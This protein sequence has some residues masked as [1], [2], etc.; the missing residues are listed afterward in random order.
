MP[1]PC[2]TRDPVVQII[3]IMIQTITPPCSPKLLATGVALGLGLLG[4]NLQAGDPVPAARQYLIAKGVHYIQT[5]PGTPVLVTNAPYQAMANV[6]PISSA[7]IF[8]VTLMIPGGD[9]LTLNT[10]DFDSQ[11]EIKDSFS[12]RAAMDAAVPNGTYTFTI[13]GADGTH[14][15]SLSLS[16]DKYPNAPHISNWAAL[17]NADGSGDILITWNAFAGGTT[18]DFVQVFVEDDMGNRFSSG[19]GPGSPDALN[20]TNTSF[21]IPAN[22][23]AGGGHFTG[24]ILFGRGS[25][26]T[27][28]YSGVQGIA[29]YFK[30]TRFSLSTTS[31]PPEAGR[32]RFA[33]S[34]YSVSEDGMDIVLTVARAGGT[35][36]NASVLVTTRPG[37][38]V[39]GFD[40]GSFS[41]RIDFGDGVAQVDMPRIQIFDH[42]TLDGN[43]T[44]FATLSA[45][46]GGADIGAPT[47]AT[48]TIVDTE[49]RGAGTFGFSAPTYTVSEAM[50][51]VPVTITRTGGSSGVVSIVYHTVSGSAEAG[52]DFIETEGTLVFSNGVTSRV[53][54]IPIVR[55]ELDET[56]ETFSVSLNNPTGGAALSMHD[57]A[58]V[59]I[60]DDDS[61]GIISFSA[62]TYSVVESD[63]NFPVIVRRTGGGADEVSVDLEITGGT[64][65][66]G[67]DYDHNGGNSVTLHF[68]AGQMAITNIFA[69]HDDRSAEGDETILL[70]LR[71][72]EGGAR[73]AGVTS[74][75]VRILDDE[76]TLQFSAT[77]YTNKE[78]AGAAVIF[79]ER[80]GPLNGPAS[81][82]VRTSGGSAS[83]DVDYVSTNVVVNFPAGAKKRPVVIRLINDA[84]VEDPETVGLVLENPSENALLGSRAESTLVIVSEDLG[85]EINFGAATLNVLESKP[86]L[87]VV[88]I[89]TGG[90]ASN[91][92]VHLATSEMSA[93]DGEDYIGANTT[94]TFAAREKVKKIRIPILQD[95]LVEGLETFALNL[96]NPTGGATLGGRSGGIAV[97]LDD[98][99]GGVISF[100]RPEIVV[101]ENGTNAV[102]IVNRVGGAAS[103]V[104]VRLT[105]ADGTATDP[106][107]GSFDEVLTFAAGERSK[108]NLIRINNDDIAEGAIPETILLRLR[109]FRGGGRPGLSNAVIRIVDDEPSVSFTNNTASATEG[110]VLTVAVARAGA[111]NTQV[112]VDYMT[113]DGT[114]TAGT[115]YRGTNGMLTFPPNVA[116]RFITIPILNDAVMETGETFRVVLKNPQG[117]V[118]L[119]LNTELVVSIQDAPDPNRARASTGPGR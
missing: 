97:I 32:F 87:S 72:P 28:A 60:K 98:D 74:A 109:E 66:R 116:V 64:A 39:P 46:T 115:Y 29:A 19:D 106:D 8:S 63:T 27:I 25:F 48:V 114:A 92:T 71:N 54:N 118:R 21:I 58:V 102:V 42:S 75:T 34:S 99:V 65:T 61:A 37:T 101:N 4:A 41:N 12:S 105:T 67:D 104:K 3:R 85:G 113:M 55:D 90:L 77:S 52:D 1:Q 5:G 20:G 100:A 79:V 94:L 119:G 6:D 51:N 96:S 112:T 62:L 10:N 14:M 40:Y 22:T 47:E 68:D 89:R 59:V 35:S 53:I 50:T 80:S 95:T 15:P 78:T 36:G 76:V 16:G 33:Q 108:T 88:I 2:N 111:L 73:L 44:F 110:R 9:I 91:V 45:P 49:I 84:L 69:I 13:T 93:H 38:A 24:E 86:F 26:N 82:H 103:E 43:K 83:P 107:Y 17:Q 23:L 70:A 56:N 7:S 57:T 117:G 81:V 11:W 30:D 18:N 31:A